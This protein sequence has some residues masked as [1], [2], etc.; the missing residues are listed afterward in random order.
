M[1][2]KESLTGEQL[3]RLELDALK[4][5]QGETFRWQPIETAP[6]RKPFKPISVLVCREGT[7]CIAI[8]RHVAKGWVH[9]KAYT[10]KLWFPPTHWMPFPLPPS[11]TPSCTAI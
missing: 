8:A 2:D 5:R 10:R 1:T 3:D 9:G 11:P 7:D 6:G 4:L